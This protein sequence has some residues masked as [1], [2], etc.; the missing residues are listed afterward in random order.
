MRFFPARTIAHIDMNSYF[1]T[2]EQQANPHLR[3]RPIGVS[4][5]NVTRQRTVVVAASIE[6]KKRGV[7]SGMSV[8]EA[9]QFC[10]ELILIPADYERY[11]EINRRFLEILDRYSA[12]IEP[13]SIDEAFF[14]VRRLGDQIGSQELKGEKNDRDGLAFDFETL[15]A[16]S[17]ESMIETALS[18]KRNIRREI[19]DC[20]TAS[21]G[22]ADNKFMAKLASESKKPDGLTVVIDRETRGPVPRSKRTVRSARF[23]TKDQLFAEVELADF[24][25]IGRQVLRRL[26][27]LGIYRPEDLA[28]IERAV[29]ISEFG[30]HRGIALWQMGQGE[31]HLP[32]ATFGDLSVERS[33]GH[34]YSLP[35][36]CSDWRSAQAVLFRLSDQV[37]RRMRRKRLFGQRIWSFLWLDDGRSFGRNRRIARPINQGR[38]IYEVARNI[39][40]EAPADFRFLPIR[41]IGLSATDLFGEDQISLSLFGSERRQ[42]RLTEALDQISGR[43]GSWSVVFAG[44]LLAKG[45]LEPIPDGRDKRLKDR[46][47]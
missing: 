40:L 12:R 37:G 44:S 42:E 34:S 7:K 38:Q 2:L 33:F 22:F 36:N 29:L 26:N 21:I 5:K 35:R 32:I 8:F 24:C 45:I 16:I 27:G 15:K 14:E 25:G 46:S 30:H 6:A 4:G 1:A 19:G 28:H 20:V 39:I 10:P 41:R 11:L 18:I 31:D 3:G 17:L 43:F 13:F 47:L 9:R 23:V